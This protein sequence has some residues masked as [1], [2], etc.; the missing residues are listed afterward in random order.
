[1]QSVARL[2]RSVVLTLAAGSKYVPYYHALNMI[3]E[4]R[5]LRSANR[6][7]LSQEHY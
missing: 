7:A 2:L 4:E 3:G 5:F 1:M 6:T